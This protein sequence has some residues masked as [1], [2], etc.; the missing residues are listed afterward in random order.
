MVWKPVKPESAPFPGIPSE[1]GG[2][3]L[4]EMEV[5]PQVYKKLLEKQR[6]ADVLPG[7]ERFSVMGTANMVFEE[8]ENKIFRWKTITREDFPDVH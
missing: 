6:I 2:L 8:I 1:L 3:A 7:K 4:Y 5:M